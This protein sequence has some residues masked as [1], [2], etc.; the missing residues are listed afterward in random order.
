MRTMPMRLRRVG[1]HLDPGAIST[2]REYHASC[3]AP[4]HKLEP[5][6]LSNSVRPIEPMH[7]L[8]STGR[9]HLNNAVEWFRRKEIG[10]TLTKFASINSPPSKG[11]LKLRKR[12]VES[13]LPSCFISKDV[14][15]AFKSTVESTISL[16]H[17]VKEYVS[18]STILI[19]EIAIIRVELTP[20]Q[21]YA[22]ALQHPSTAIVR[23]RSTQPSDD[24]H[25]Y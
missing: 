5:N 18:Y 15:S 2:L 20:D 8:R 14:P 11:R 1:E 6:H 25:W 9:N 24:D 10:T 4:E 16:T 13:A 23:E 19:A 12:I 7:L 21:A 17:S 22:I 3:L